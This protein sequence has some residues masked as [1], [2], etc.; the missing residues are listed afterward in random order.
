MG[1]GVSSLVLPCRASRVLASCSAR[2]SSLTQTLPALLWVEPGCFSGM[3]Y[4]ETTVWLL[5]TAA[6]VGFYF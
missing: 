6:L 3:Q 5:I 4:L 2:S 1:A